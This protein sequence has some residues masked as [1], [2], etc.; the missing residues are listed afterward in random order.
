[1]TTT[2]SKPQDKIGHSGARRRNRAR[3]VQPE[4]NKPD[5]YE[6]GWREI[7]RITDE[8]QVVRERQPLTLWDILHPQEGDFRLHTDEHETFCAYLLDVF[9]AQV[10]G[11]PGAF[12]LHD[13]RVAWS[14]TSGIEAHG[15]DIAVIFNVREYDNWATFDENKEA[16]R[17]TLIVEIVSPKTR[18]VDTEYKLEEY[19][20]VGVEYYVIVDAHIRRRRTYYSLL[21]YRLVNGAYQALDPNPHGWLWL[22]PL[23]LWIGLQDNW[24]VCL[25]PQGKV[26]GDY[27]E[28]NEARKAAEEEVQEAQRQVQ[29]AQRQAQEAQH[30]AREAQRQAQEAELRAAAEQ[31]TRLELEVR[32]Q[33]I[34]AE[35]RQLRSKQST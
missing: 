23:Q 8:G 5:R 12:V 4:P 11:I 30:Q 17:P 1:M 29:E 35:L 18:R 20:Q 2:T 28:V 21:G 14:T 16:T 6:Y 13:T 7:T 22:E 26:I 3:P 33:A 24:L 34:E 32:L 10:E 9:R 27:V 15:P 31:Q 25:D 19:A